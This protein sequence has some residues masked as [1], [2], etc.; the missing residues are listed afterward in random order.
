MPYERDQVLCDCLPFCLHDG[1]PPAP[2]KCRARSDWYVTLCS[3]GE[4]PG[5]FD[6][7]CCHKPSQQ[8]DPDAC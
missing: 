3:K 7:L 6:K 8:P 5:P 1:K 2:Q 4:C